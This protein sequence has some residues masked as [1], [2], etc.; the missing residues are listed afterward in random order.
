LVIL[1]ERIVIEEF[2]VIGHEIGEQDEVG[3]VGE[4]F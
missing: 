1:F 4:E 2:D 3:I